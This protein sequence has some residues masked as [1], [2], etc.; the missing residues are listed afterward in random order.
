MSAPRTRRRW[1]EVLRRTTGLD[2]QAPRPALDDAALFAALER[3]TAATLDV[4]RHAER[5]GAASTRQRTH[6]DAAVERAG[7]VGA[8]LDRASVGLRRA[9]EVLDRLGVVAL[10]AGLEGARTPEPHGRAL[11]LVADE[12]RALV[13]RGV[14]ALRDATETLTEA[15][16]S[17]ASVGERLGR[18]QTEVTDVGASTTSVKSSA[19]DAS[20]ALADVDARL[21]KATGLD[22]ERARRLAAANEH[23]K[24]LVE[25]LSALELSEGSDIAR[26][27]A[28]VLSRVRA[29]VSEVVPSDVPDSDPE[30][31]T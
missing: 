16:S 31:G 7:E 8:R 14:E 24:G 21:R 18:V 3:A 1:L 15:A 17:A 12:V 11:G 28:P 2:A 25:A 29:I 19:H 10:N 30:G 22:P 5:A 13:A 20:S 4:E 6:A 26:S 27:L 23:A 9:I